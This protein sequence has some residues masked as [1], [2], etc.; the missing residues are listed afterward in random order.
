MLKKFE[1]QKL[2]NKAIIM[3]QIIFKRQFPI[4]IHGVKTK[5]MKYLKEKIQ[6]IKKDC[7]KKNA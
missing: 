6:P 4:L 5:N 3:Q 7:S 1:N 2:M